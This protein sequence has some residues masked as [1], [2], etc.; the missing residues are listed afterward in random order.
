MLSRRSFLPDI[1]FRNRE[2]LKVLNDSKLIFNTMVPVITILHSL[3]SNNTLAATLMARAWNSS[4]ELQTLATIWCYD[5][6]RPFPNRK[7]N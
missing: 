3:P 6:V 4:T 2:P 5:I 7:E 1:Y